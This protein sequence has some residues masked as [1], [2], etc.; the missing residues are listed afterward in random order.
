MNPDRAASLALLPI[1][2]S[3]RK[4]ALSYL[5]QAVRARKRLRTSE[6]PEALHDFRVAL[7]RMRSALRVFR[8][9]LKGSSPRRL[10][11]ALRDIASGTG[12]SRDLE[13]HLEWLGRKLEELPAAPRRGIEALAARLETR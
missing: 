5:E 4:V 10:S 8:P 6:D 7:R 13:V 3:A 9:H 1:E 2:E 11:R 12:M